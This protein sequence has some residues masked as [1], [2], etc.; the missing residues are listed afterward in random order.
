MRFDYPFTKAVSSEI[1]P[2][3]YKATGGLL[4]EKKEEAFGDIAATFIRTDYI[5][6]KTGA[7]FETDEVIV[8]IEKL[9]KNIETLELIENK[10][11]AENA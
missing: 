8:L 3:F 1:M 2:G 11:E 10:E 5:R 4:S 6:Y 9:I 7:S